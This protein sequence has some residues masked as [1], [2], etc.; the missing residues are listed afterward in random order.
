MCNKAGGNLGVGDGLGCWGK[1]VGKF[2]VV[3]GSF[4]CVGGVL[5]VGRDLMY[6]GDFFMVGEGLM[7]V[8]SF[9]KLGVV[10]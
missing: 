9:L 1:V 8:G 10:G 5:M 3:G 2:L 7:Y 4:M 6:V